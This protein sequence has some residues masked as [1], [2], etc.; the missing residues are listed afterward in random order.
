MPST[1]PIPM[2]SPPTF[3]HLAREL[4]D[5]PVERIRLLPT[6]GSATIADIERC[7]MCE[8]IDGTLVEKAMGLPESFIA[9]FLSHA[10]YSYLNDHPL[11]KIAGPDGTWQI[12]PGLVRLP[13][14][15]FISWDRLPGRKV[16]R[17]AVPQLT[18]DLV[19]EVL[20][21]GNTKGEME[22]KRREY[23]R[24]GV[25]LIWIVDRFANSVTEYTS[26]NERRILGPDD[27]LDGGDI[28]PDFTLSVRE[29]LAEA[30]E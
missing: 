6:P 14:I 18:P 5:I 26:V 22:R 19:I 28:L 29:L 2:H 12:E 8:L 21:V 16:P 17:E 25:R 11:G 9:T 10:I 27:F 24:A 20:S 7:K 30:G 4:G 13:D 3:D 1:V 15:A 23:F